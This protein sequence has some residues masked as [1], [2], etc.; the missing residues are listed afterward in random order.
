VGCLGVTE[1]GVQYLLTKCYLPS[2]T[3]GFSGMFRSIGDRC[4]ILVD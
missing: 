4:S 3:G 1:T 2:I